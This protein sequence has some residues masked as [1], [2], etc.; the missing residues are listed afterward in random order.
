MYRLSILEV[1]RKLHHDDAFIQPCPFC[2]KIIVIWDFTV[3][4]KGNGIPC[5]AAVLGYKN[6]VFRTMVVGQNDALA[7][8]P[9]E[10]PLRV[11]WNHGS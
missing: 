8:A 9:E 5:V 11:V 10:D 4:I 6:A 2:L 3:Q 1:G 7:L